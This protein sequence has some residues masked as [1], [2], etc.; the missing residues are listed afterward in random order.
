MS[1]QRVVGLQFV[2][3]V[4]RWNERAQPM[5]V[6]VRLFAS[7]VVPVTIAPGQTV[8][9]PPRVLTA[10]QVQQVAGESADLRMQLFFGLKTVRFE[11]GYEWRI[12]PNPAAT[13][14]SEALNIPSPVYTRSWT[15]DDPTPAAP[16]SGQWTD[17]RHRPYSPGALV[18]RGDQS[19]RFMRC[20]N[21][22]WVEAT[23][24]VAQRTAPGK[25]TAGAGFV[26][27]VCRESLPVQDRPPDSDA[28]A[29]LSTP[30]AGT[31]YANPERTV[32]AWWWGRTSEGSYKVVWIHGGSAPIEI[33]GRRLDG[34]AP[35]LRTAIPETA[36]WTYQG[37]GLRF[38][39]SGCWELEGVTGSWRMTFVVNVASAALP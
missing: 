1:A 25:V 30:P 21:G 19:G 39:A 33:R 34:D 37:A 14:G 24:G 23:L 3:A 12:T 4:E 16:A 27:G 17:D 6:P 20:V 10:A 38:P 18:P 22:R 8:Q 5:R 15:R 28:H 29:A 35:L 2:A 26:E 11:N 31:W 7:D 9:V 13:T 32:W 36:P